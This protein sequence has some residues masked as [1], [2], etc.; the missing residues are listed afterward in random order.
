MDEVLNK[1][2]VDIL[3]AVQKSK[4]SQQR[5]KKIFVDKSGSSVSL[6]Q[7]TDATSTFY[8]NQYQN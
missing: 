4:K 5:H 1:M 8:S 7:V 6:R 3:G 2:F